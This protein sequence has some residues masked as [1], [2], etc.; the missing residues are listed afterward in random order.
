MADAFICCVAED[1]D[2]ATGRRVDGAWRV[3]LGSNGRPSIPW[4][5]V[6]FIPGFMSV[7]LI[8]CLAAV[9]AACV[10]C[11][12]RPVNERITAVDPTHGYRL[13]VSLANRNNNDP[14][15]TL[16][17]AFSGGGTRAAAC[18]TKST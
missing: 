12:S 16:V 3:V 13:E 18:S 5:Y 8:P 2:R 6:R 1:R 7:R 10:G 17:L 4:R 15:T 14:R 9:A 11:A